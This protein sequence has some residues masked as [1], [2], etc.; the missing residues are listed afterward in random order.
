MKEVQL[1]DPYAIPY[2]GIYAICDSNNEY[3][4]LIEDTNCYGGAAWAKHHYLQ[5]PIVQQINSFGTTTRYLAKVKKSKLNLK[6]SIMPAGIESISVEG[7]FVKV[8]YAG[9]G[10]GGVGA[11]KCRAMADGVIDY[12][13]TTSGGGRAAKGTIIIPRRERLLIGVDDTDTKDEGATWALAHNIAKALSCNESIYLSHSIVQLFPVDRKTQNCVSIVLEFACV[14][15]KVKNE[16]I[17]NIK[18]ALLKYSVSKETGMVAYSGFNA[19]CLNGYSEKCRS[20]EITRDDALESIK[21][22]SVQVLLNGDGI[23]GALAAIP[24]FAKPDLSVKF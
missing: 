19:D 10:G 21:K 17:I 2:K 1:N 9:L 11:T 13:I 20:R 15:E 6:S 8:T 23:I 24:W 3:V 22:N 5:S 14:N 7:N 4:E 12:N 16:I 18:N